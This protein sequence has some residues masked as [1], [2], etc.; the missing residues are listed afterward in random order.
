MKKLILL[1]LLILTG[2]YTT[3]EFKTAE[4]QK[5]GGLKYPA[6]IVVADSTGAC[7]GRTGCNFTQNFVDELKN[8][9][10]F[11]DVSTFNPNAGYRVKIMLRASSINK[12]SLYSETGGILP[13]DVKQTFNST[14]EIE[15]A[16]HTL[17]TYN[18]NA[19]GVRTAHAFI[20][21]DADSMTKEAI[22]S[23]AANFVANLQRD[24]VLPVT[25]K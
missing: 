13:S 3:P 1:T 21:Q 11:H 23:F 22:K 24:N 12:D 5:F 25:D 2:C 8:T 16:T 9:G 15:D 19:T 17:Y 7:L 18:F 20:K 4:Y 6:V 14:F 10:A